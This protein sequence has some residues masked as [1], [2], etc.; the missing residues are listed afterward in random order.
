MAGA[1]ASPL[2]AD[3]FLLVLICYGGLRR[4]TLGCV[5]FLYRRSANAVYPATHL[6]LAAETGGLIQEPTYVQQMHRVQSLP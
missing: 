1:T 4:S 5:R 3:V 6:C 2:D